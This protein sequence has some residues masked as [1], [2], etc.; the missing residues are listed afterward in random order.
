MLSRL[1]PAWLKQPS[2]HHTVLAIALPIMVSNVS[3]P[4]IGLADTW[5]IGRLP[6]PYFIGAI[7][8]GA[9]IFSFIFWGFGFLRM[10]TGGLA[11]QA[12]GAGDAEELRAVLGRALLIALGAGLLLIALSPLIE[13]AAFWLLRGSEEVEHHARIYFQIRVLSAPFALA[14]YALLGWFIGLADA[15]T[16]LWL[17]L[18]LNVS[19]IVLD[20]LLV[21]GLGMTSDGVALGTLLASVIACGAGLWIAQ[22]EL[23]R[24]GGGWNLARIIDRVQLKRMAVVNF[25]IMIR[26]VAVVFAFSIFTA[27]SAEVSDLVL[28]ANTILMNLLVFGTYVLD[29]FAHS[30]EA[31]VGQAV[32]AKD[33][34]RFRVYAWLSAKWALVTSAVFA[35]ITW[36]LGGIMIDAL[37]VNLE[38]RETARLYLIWIVAAPVVGVACYQLDGIFIGATQTRDLRNM[39]LLAVILYLPAWHYLVQYFGNHGLWASLMLFLALRGLTLWI[40]MPALLRERFPAD[41]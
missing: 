24:R 3:E 38:I 12:E 10:G 1:A 9:L 21:L 25:D 27:K 28:A 35:L 2:A 40:R 4:L 31:L 30:A 36:L 14:N 33:Q 22:R 37:T 19:N 18:I 41:T 20:V 13:S 26:S 11:A 15:R 39:M 5:V 34:A 29:G 7:A 8:L 23:N 16:A 17:Q 6:E 32:G